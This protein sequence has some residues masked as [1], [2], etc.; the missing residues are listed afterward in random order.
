MSC[1]HCGSKYLEGMIDI[2]RPG[3][4][5]DL[6]YRLEKRGG[7][8]VLISGGCDGNG[9]VM[10][11]DHTFEEIKELKDSTDLLVNMHVG[12]IG[13]TTAE[14]VADAGVDRVSFD[15]VLHDDTIRNVLHLSNDSSAY[16]RTL[17]LLERY[18]LN[19]VPHILAGL[20]HGR[21]SW[22]YDAVMELSSR[23]Y[24]K[25]VLIVI[26]PTKGT[27]M[28]NVVPPDTGD[29]LSLAG[30]MR[31]SLASVLAL[32]CMRPKGMVDLELGI[33]DIGFEGIVLPSK[34]TRRYAREKGWKVLDH[35]ICCCF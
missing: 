31:R 27:G 13:E 21:I 19:V 8:G 11:P 1:E 32:G 26:I 12:L 33:L 10:F 2:S 7:K 20:D 17:D 25:V 28:E 24:D 29:V 30:S 34:R 5:I 22:E 4:L 3:S 18:D 14:K 9:A 23:S 35:D 15:L 16:L 6:G